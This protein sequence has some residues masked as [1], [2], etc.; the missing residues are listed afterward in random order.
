MRLT[1]DKLSSIR[2]DLVRVDDNRQEWDLS[3]LADSLR[4]WTDR[5]PEN[6]LND[7][8]KHRSEGVFQTKEQKPSP[9]AC[10]YCDK[11][12]H[13]ASQCESVRSAEDRSLILS[14]KKLF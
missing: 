10:V 5:N 12:G 2:A 14:K 1:L 11:Q 7:D 13:K 8:Q 3:N 6:I 4:R 9:C